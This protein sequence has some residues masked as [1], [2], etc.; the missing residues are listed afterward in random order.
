[1]D[2]SKAL[3]RSR[4]IL[5]TQLYVADPLNSRIQVFDPNGFLTNGHSRGKANWARKIA[6]TRRE[7]AI[8]IQH[9]HKRRVYF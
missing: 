9:K 7:A 2:I 4:S 6:S 8:R 1:M 3:V 5:S